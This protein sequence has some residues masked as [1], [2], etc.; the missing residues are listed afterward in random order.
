MSLIREQ[1]AFMRDVRRLLEFA[2]SRQLLVTGGELE[3]SPEAQA[4]PSTRSSK[5][6]AP[7][8]KVAT[9]RVAPIPLD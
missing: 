1:A 9:L 6:E 4:R 5:R 3:R 7:A 8:H 2:E